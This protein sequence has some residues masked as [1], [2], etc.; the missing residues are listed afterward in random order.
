MHIPFEYTYQ[1]LPERFYSRIAPISSKEPELALFNA[2]LALSLGLSPDELLSSHPESLFSGNAFSEDEHTIAL[3]YAGHQFGN[4]VPQLG[5]GR[6]ILLGELVDTDGIRRDIQLKG[7]GRTPYSRR[8]DGRSA[9]GP[10]IREYVLSEAMHHLGIP[11]TRALAAVTSGETVRR[12]SR[13]PGGVFTRVASSH[14]RI[15]TFEY[16]AVRKDI[17]GLQLLAEYTIDRHYPELRREENPY[18]AL[19]HTVIG[20]QAHLV[21]QWMAVGFIHGVMN[22]D[23]MSIS[24]ETIDYGPCAFMDAFDPATVYSYIDRNG[25]YA[26]ANQGPIA[27][28]N[29]ARFAESLL[30]I[31]AEEQ[32]EAVSLANNA[33]QTFGDIFRS[34]W[35]QAMGSKLGLSTAV[36]D[37]FSLIE[38]FL[39]ILLENEADY[40]NSFRSLHGLLLERSISDCF[41][42]PM[43]KSLEPWLPRW[44]KRLEQ[45]SGSHAAVA[46]TMRL[47]N[48]AFIPRNHRVEEVIQAAVE[49]RNFE[50]AK[51]LSGILSRPFV[52][53]GE[54]ERFMA[55]PEEH[56][57][58]QHTFCGT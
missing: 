48:P 29:L 43:R 17:E 1:T 27:Q 38:E 32:K 54:H 19:L 28:W 24:G 44:R 58:V 56:E 10:V 7:A 5:D 26:Y 42:E 12:E 2:E 35:L 45:E 20:V 53:Q 11:T 8:G 57:V 55:P 9:L 52:D 13:L 18:V 41:S 47:S 36:D 39:N 3:A 6:A 37:D 46:E 23:N 15:G 50:P 33:V 25:R 51:L 34:A 16:F 49:D 14:I 31:L 22:T 30:P 4:F 21:A 40:T